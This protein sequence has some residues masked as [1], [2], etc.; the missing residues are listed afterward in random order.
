[1]VTLE[2]MLKMLIDRK[3]SDLHLSSGCEPYLR[4]HGIMVKTEFSKLTNNDIQDL[5][6]GILS[7]KQRSSFLEKWELDCNYSVQGLS[8]F[9]LNVFMQHRGLSAVFRGIPETI[10]SIEDLGLPSYLKNIV[11]VP[12]GLIVVTG[13]TGSGKSTTLAALIHHINQK[14]RKHIV[15]IEDPIEFIHPN[16]LSLINQREVLNHTKSFTNALKAVLREDPDVILVGE[17]RDLETMELA[18][19]AAETGHIVFATLH[20]NGAPQTIDRI[21]NV[22]PTDQQEQIRMMLAEGLRG[23]IS[24]LLVPRCDREGRVATLEIL[25]K[26]P[27]ISSLIRSKKTFQIVSAMQTGKGEGMVTFEQY[28]SDLVEKKIIT[29]EVM[30]SHL[31]V[32]GKV[33]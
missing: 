3:G 19:K 21:I 6:F 1:M 23:I 22:F 11:E 20:T 24:Q 25:I 28:F 32:Q 31:A 30:Y 8:R 2:V 27:A 13:P 33:S 4:I 9:R 26:N 18:I 14:K 7:E 29:Q 15:T 10:P 12:N 5:I 16:Q 17:L